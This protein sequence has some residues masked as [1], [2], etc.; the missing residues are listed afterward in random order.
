MLVLEKQV[1]GTS[2]NLSQLMNVTKDIHQSQ[3]SIP[4]KQFLNNAILSLKSQPVYINMQPPFDYIASDEQEKM[5]PIS[6]NGY[7]KNT[8]GLV[9]VRI[10]SPK[11]P[12]VFFA[13]CELIDGE[14]WMMIQSR[15]DGSVSFF[16]TWM[17]YVNGFGNLNGEFW[18]G[19]DKLH[20][21]T[22][23][24]LQELLVIL[25]DFDGVEKRAHYSAFAIAGEREHFALT[26]L[27]NYNGTAGD[28]LNYHAGHKFS[29]FDLDN[30]GWKEGN[31]AQAHQGGW[32]YNECDM[33][34]LNGRYLTGDVP[35]DQ[36]YKGI[37]WNDFRG[38]S[39]S[40][41]AS[42]MLIRPAK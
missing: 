32:W 37:Y 20:A 40:L 26:V 33:S 3:R 9:K 36:E 28:S 2:F 31:C 12:Q 24:E 8:T 6:C 42:K 34:N 19:L 17:D 18:I 25:E 15:E 4:T 14:P 41:K 23:G 29:T 10:P 38:N 16:K 39:Y 21:I 30:D 22:S 11:F 1:F 35:G 13:R 7:S 27:G 5:L